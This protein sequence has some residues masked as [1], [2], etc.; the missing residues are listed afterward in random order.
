ME[1]SNQDEII[2]VVTV[3]N[4]EDGDQNGVEANGVEAEPIPDRPPPKRVEILDCNSLNGLMYHYFAQGDYIECKSLIGEIQSKYKE[5]NEAAFHVRGLIARNEGELEEAM[6]CF[7][8]AYQLSGKNKKYFY[9][10]GRCNFL[11]GRHQIAVEQLRKASEVMKDNPKV[12]Y[13]MARA[14][15]HLPSEKIP[16]KTFNPTET[17]RNLLMG[18]TVAKDTELI[19][20]LGRLCEELQDTEGA[21]AAYESAMKLQPDNTDVMYR[22]ALVLLRMGKEKEGFEQLGN[23]LAYD[24]SNS[25]AILTLGSVMQQHYDHDVALNKYR[26]AADACD[27]NGCLWNNIGIGL[28]ARNKSAAAHSALKKAS[29]ISPLDYKISFNLG[30]LHD[31]M[32][33]HC[34]ALH[35]IKLC[36]E[37]KPNNAKAV[38]AMAVIM[39]HMNDVKNARAAYKKSIE[40]QPSPSIVLNYAIF[41]YR[42][43]NFAAA[44]TAVQIYKQLESSGMKCSANHK[45][46]ASLLDSVLKQHE[47]TP[48][49]E[50]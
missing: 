45:Q 19:T 40:L 43:K 28:L 32:K 26:V 7:E 2:G 38:G 8:K 23:C 13:W 25:Q 41:E 16:G 27:Y 3:H 48:S 46:T 33:L 29:F 24:P 44:S 21:I 6:D 42:T 39:S 35:Y 30:V 18:S 5:K 37:L 20:F 9:E 49:A 17:A 34:S 10:T 11:L 22:L 50:N 47:E 14:I 4:E 15:Y 1:E 36:T 31:I 12:W